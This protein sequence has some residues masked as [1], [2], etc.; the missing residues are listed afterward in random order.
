MGWKLSSALMSHVFANIPTGE[1]EQTLQAWLEANP[2]I[3]L[4]HMAQSQN[5]EGLVTL[6]LVYVKL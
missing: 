6:T 2:S 4:M 3:R 1:L 5:G